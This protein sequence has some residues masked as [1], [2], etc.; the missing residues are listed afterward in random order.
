MIVSKF[1]PILLLSLQGRTIPCHAAVVAAA[2]PYLATLVRDTSTDTGHT[3]SL[4]G[5]TYSQVK[6]I[7]CDP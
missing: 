3:L 5:I 6:N 4:V 7:C 1:Y 2:S